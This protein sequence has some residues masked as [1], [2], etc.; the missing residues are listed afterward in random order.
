MKNQ[1]GY[2]SEMCWRCYFKQQL[3]SLTTGNNLWLSGCEACVSTNE[4][5]FISQRGCGESDG[6]HK[7]L[8]VCLK[9]ET[10]VVNTFCCKINATNTVQKYFLVLITYSTYDAVWYSIDMAVCVCVMAVWCVGGCE[11][12]CF[13]QLPESM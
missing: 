5:I 11:R 8:M 10:D 13:P 1:T 12:S 3:G 9:D 7:R 4:G 2:K 6:S